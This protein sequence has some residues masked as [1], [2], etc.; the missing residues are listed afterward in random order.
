MNSKA[1]INSEFVFYPQNAPFD[2]CHSS[3]IAETPAGLLCAWFAGPY[4]GH[5]DVEIWLGRKVDGS[6]TNPVN[7][8]DDFENNKRYPAWNPV[9][10]YENGKTILFYKVGPHPF[11]WWGKYKISTD[12]GKSWSD[13][14]KLPNSFIGPVRN[15]PV[16]LNNGELL[17]PSSTEN[18]GWRLHLEFTPNLG[19][20]W[21]R[22]SALNDEDVVSAIQ[23]TILFHGKNKLQLL[24]RTR[25]S[26]IYTA[27]STDSGRTWTPLEPI[28]LPN[29]NSAIDAVTMQDGRHL[30]VF[31]HIPGSMDQSKRNI[32]NVAISEDGINW[33]AALLLEN[34]MDVITDKELVLNDVGLIH[35]ESEYSYPAIIQ[36]SD[37]TLHI[38]YTWKRH[39]IKHVT[40]EPNKI[41]SK[42][43]I[44]GN[45]P[46]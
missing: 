24:C 1:I 10:Y 42:P 41:E 20:T 43:F 21:E 27:W 11:S 4:E 36:S 9:L 34:E 32:L 38:S 7:I 44:N 33:E 39:T 23:P 35:T 14:Q 19:K 40:V 18:D 2:S 22:T 46:E 25:N 3:T 45:W 26:F 17:C 37:G 13:P 29:P 12:N 8:A 5:P 16:L 30:L 6:W 31:N 28:D 15:K